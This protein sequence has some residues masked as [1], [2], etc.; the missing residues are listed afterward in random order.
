MLPWRRDGRIQTRRGA[1]PP[2]CF[3]LLLRVPPCSI[4]LPLP[5][6]SGP[7]LGHPDTRALK[8]VVPWTC[9]SPL[10]DQVSDCFRGMN[11]GSC[12][13]METAGLEGSCFPLPPFLGPWTL[14][15]LCP[16]RLCLRALLCAL[17]KIKTIHNFLGALVQ[18]IRD[19][20]L[21]QDLGAGG[22]RGARTP[23]SRRCAYM[24]AP[25]FEF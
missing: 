9:F 3:M 10:R 19:T 16:L 12:H 15:P 20:H 5:L 11:T 13:A 21:F 22:I 6:A 17:V 4:S 2:H 23:G 7:V 1:G 24:D 18:G 25:N 8:G 14:C